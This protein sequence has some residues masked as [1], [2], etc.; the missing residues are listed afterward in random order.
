MIKKVAIA[1]G[2]NFALTDRDYLLQFTKSRS[3]FENTRDQGFL[4]LNSIE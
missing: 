4:L 1:N 3:I 2:T